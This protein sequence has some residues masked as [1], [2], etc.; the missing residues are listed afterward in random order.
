[1]GPS[2]NGKSQNWLHAKIV[3]RES[4]YDSTEIFSVLYLLF[5]VTEAILTD[6]YYIILV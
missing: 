5:V 4:A 3:V 2:W 6:H 1:M